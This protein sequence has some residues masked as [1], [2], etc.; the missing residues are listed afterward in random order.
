M[1]TAAIRR[2]ARCG[3]P[4][5]RARGSHDRAVAARV[6]HGFRSA[7]PGEAQ[8]YLE[9]PL[10]GGCGAGALALF[11]CVATGVMAGS[12][13]HAR[14]SRPVAQ[15]ERAPLDAE[16]RWMAAGSSAPLGNRSAFADQVAAQA[17]S[18]GP[19]GRMARAVR[20]ARVRR[21]GRVAREGAAGQIIERRG[22][23]LL[24]DPRWHR[25]PIGLHLQQPQSLH[26]LVVGQNHARA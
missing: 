11:A 19:A 13:A 7:G 21:L 26:Q 20:S 2:V 25:V 9:L 15:V 4:E 18:V 8:P 14:P 23:P 1:R 22:G 3:H 16:R 17:S 5:V 6:D 12:T 24:S 10:G